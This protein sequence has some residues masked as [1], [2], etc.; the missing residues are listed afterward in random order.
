MLENKGIQLLYLSS[1]E[2]PELL[3]N[4]ARPPTV[5]YV[6]G[7]IPSLERSI[8][9]VGTRKITAHGVSATQKIVH[10]LIKNGVTIISGMAKGVD[11]IAHETALKSGG[12]TIAVLGSGLDIIFPKENEKLYEAIVESGGAVM[13]EFPLETPPFR[14]NFPMRN[15]IVAGLAHATIIT[16]SYK[17]GGAM[18]TASLALDEG[19]DVFA[20]PGFLSYPSFE[21]NNT[22]IKYFEAKLITSGDDVL[23]EY[24]WTS[25]K[26]RVKATL[27]EKFSSDETLIL[28]MLKT[29][30][31]LDKIV[32]QTA[33]SS[34]EALIIL[35][36]LE[37]NGHIKKQANRYVAL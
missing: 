5:L 12:K 7:K 14:W 35:T 6:R 29:G 3:K 17:R 25:Q 37:L 36:E 13:S 22:L 26:S 1:R 30:A 27:T 4:I 11:T 15:R 9:V 20:V 33:L 10:R 16:E 24:Q 23:K 18:I 31:S 2:Y 21:G 8:A 34:Q 32:A 28:G 19:R